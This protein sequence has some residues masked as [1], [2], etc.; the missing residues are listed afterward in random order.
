MQVKQNILTGQRV[1]KI[2]LF[3]RK[4]LSQTQVVDGA[5]G[6]LLWAAEFVCPR[7]R[8]EA[9]AVSTSAGQSA[10]LFWASQPI[11]AQK[12]ITKATVSLPQRT[13]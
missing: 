4:H 6:R 1:K 2:E 8:V 7:V 5:S 11:R 10:F 13:R 12:S 3:L 9:L